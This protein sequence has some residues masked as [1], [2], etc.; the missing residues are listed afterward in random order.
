[1]P[2]FWID[3]ALAASTGLLLLLGAP[4]WSALLGAGPEPSTLLGIGWFLVPWSA[5]NAWTA[6]LKPLRR[7]IVLVHLVFDACWIF[8]SLAFIARDAA[9]LSLV[10]HLLLLA[11]A[12]LVAWVFYRKRL[13][14]GAQAMRS[15]RPGEELAAR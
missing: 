1:M 15:H 14:G 13:E 11:Q 4:L 3:A 10:G 8:A 5:F 6:T 7:T 2:I 12:C 9:R